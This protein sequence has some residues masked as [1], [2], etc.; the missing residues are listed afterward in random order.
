MMAR[1]PACGGAVVIR[2]NRR[3]VALG[4]G[5]RAEL[6]AGAGVVV[7]SGAA[8]ASAVDG[9]GVRLRAFAG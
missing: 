1:W 2:C 7:V 8:S 9:F 4:A 5:D 6:G 3:R